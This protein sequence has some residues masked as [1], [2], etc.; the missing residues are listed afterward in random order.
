VSVGV[1]EEKGGGDGAV[2]VVIGNNSRSRRKTAMSTPWP[3]L[4]S[5]V[6]SPVNALNWEATRLG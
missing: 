6:S 3:L 4:S 5:A 1:K 2:R